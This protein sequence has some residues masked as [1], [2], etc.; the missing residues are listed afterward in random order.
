MNSKNSIKLGVA[1]ALGK[2]GSRILDLASGDSDFRIVLALERTAHSGLGQRAGGVDITSQLEK[3][4]GVDV[5]IDFSSP[6]GTLEHLKY[7]EKFKKPLIIGTTG[8]S[9]A[10]KK[11]I[12]RAAKKIAIVLAPNMSIGVNLLFDLVR[13]A[14]KKLP[15]NYNVRITEAH[16]IHK[17]DAPSGTAKFL[18]EIIKRERGLESVDIKSIRE[19]EIIGDHEVVFESPFDT[20]KLSHFAKT[21]DIFAK[22][23]LEAAKFVV[24]KK[25]GFFAMSDALKERGR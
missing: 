4:K 19:G 1:G 22:G 5:L 16:H 2:M 12:A 8:F 6:E 18:A 3:I 10:Q 24:R 20:L 17:K 23:A 7:C 11:A 21:R 13:G 9:D 14:S 15:Q 25:R